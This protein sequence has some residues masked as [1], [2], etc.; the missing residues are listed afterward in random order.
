M[1]KGWKLYYVESDGYKDC[2]IVARNKAEAITVDRDMN[3]FETNDLKTTLI[4][5]IPDSL[6]KVADAHFLEW[7]KNNAPWHVDDIKS[8]KM[9][10]WPF[11]ADRRL[12][13]ELGASFRVAEGYDEILL[14]GIVYAC[15]PNG[16]HHTRTIGV[17][18]LWEFNP[19]LPRVVPNDEETADIKPLIYQILGMAL[20]ESQEIEWLLN[21]SFIFAFSS[22]QRRKIKTINEAI[23]CWSRKTLGAMVNIMKESFEFSEDVDN[24]FKLFIDMRNRLVHDILMSER[25]NIET[26]WGQR[27][28]MAYLD[29]FLKLCEPIKEI[30]TAC[31]DISFA[32]SED[33]F[34]NT[35]PNWKRN[36]DLIKLFASCFAT[37]K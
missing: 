33:L 1:S 6:E 16:L 30:A 22:K 5:D 7:A 4:C 25:Y 14:D 23:S 28:L 34:D 11:Y 12:L 37:K 13:K 32:L 8:G 19:D 35:I 31:C 26:N 29:M 24:G 3:S 15:D 2:F 18:A 36:P 21:H 10:A 27:E 20:K 17:R 9:H